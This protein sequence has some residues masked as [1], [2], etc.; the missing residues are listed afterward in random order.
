MIKKITFT[1]LMGIFA[2]SLFAQ[3]DMFKLGIRGGISTTEIGAEELIVTNEADMD[4]L[5]LRIQEANYGYHIGLFAQFQAGKFFI[6]PEIL[7]NSNSVDFAVTDFGLIESAPQILQENYQYLDIP[8]MLGV[9]LGP[10]R[11]QG[12]PV[13]HVFLNSS[14][15]LFAIQGYEEKFEEF[16]YGYQAGIGIDFWKFVIDVKYEGNFNNF[17]D[18]INIDGRSYDFSQAPTRLI[19]SVGIAF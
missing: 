6:Q 14:S 18:H 1:L 5:E 2:V 15:E 9:K 4:I 7:F 10:L 3:K 12:G 19:A 11:L 17:G 8:L 13:G 16:T